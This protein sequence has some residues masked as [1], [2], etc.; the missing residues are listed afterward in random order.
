MHENDV[1]RL[2]PYMR[3]HLTVHGHYPLTAP[4]PGR[5]RRPLRDPDTALEEDS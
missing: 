2:S 4:G 1:A 5:P 3:R